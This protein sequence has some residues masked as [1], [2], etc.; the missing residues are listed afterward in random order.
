MDV[1][2][3]IWWQVQ[4]PGMVTT[5]TPLMTWQAAEKRMLLFCL[6]RIKINLVR[7]KP[8]P[9]FGFFQKPLPVILPLQESEP[10]VFEVTQTRYTQPG[11]VQRRLIIAF[12]SGPHPP[13]FL[14]FRVQFIARAVPHRC[15]ERGCVCV[16][17]GMRVNWKIL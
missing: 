15:R 5:Q 16:W 11:K 9:L 12:F 4:C 14:S 13:H 2:Y 10:R 17:G 7:G 8:S 3:D 6:L 1:I